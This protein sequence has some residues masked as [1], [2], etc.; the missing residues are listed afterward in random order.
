MKGIE[1]I[2]K[3]GRAFNGNIKQMVYVV[4]FDFSNFMEKEWV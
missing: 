3:I 2:W 4:D 1:S